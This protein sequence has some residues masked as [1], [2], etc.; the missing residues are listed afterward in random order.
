[1][2]SIIRGGVLYRVPYVRTLEWDANTIIPRKGR[3]GLMKDSC[4]I[5]H[6]SCDWIEWEWESEGREVEVSESMIV[7]GSDRW[8]QQSAMQHLVVGFPKTERATGPRREPQNLASSMG[9]S[10]PTII[11]H[12]SSSASSSSFCQLSLTSHYQLLLF[13]SSAKYH[14][15]VIISA[16]SFSLTPPEVL[17][18][19][20]FFIKSASWK[21]TKMDK[22]GTAKS[23]WFGIFLQ[24]WLLFRFRREPAQYR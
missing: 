13:L 18:E 17:F 9:L 7:G 4:C 12:N 24:F 11:I 3:Q 5:W 16:W 20:S 10:E 19:P 2:H 6:A 22:Q 15:H 8:W 14:P 23:P 1:M 21:V